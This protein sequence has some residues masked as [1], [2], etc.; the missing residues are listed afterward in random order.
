[1]SHNKIT[2]QGQNPDSSGNV[3]LASLN[4]GDLNNVT[5]SSPTT[6]QVIKYDG[7]GYVNADSPGATVEYIRIGQGESNLYSNSGAANLNSGSALR[8]Y[9]TSPLNTITGA[10]LT[11]YSTSDWYSSFSLPAGKYFLLSQFNVE[12]SASGY[13]AAQLINSSS[14]TRSMKAVVGDNAGA[15]IDGASTSITGLFE[16]SGSETIELQIT[17]ASN[18]DGTVTTPATSTNFIAEN[19]FIYIQKVD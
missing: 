13:I 18:V 6:N 15:L 1:M 16:L 7:A 2:V 17:N 12:F 19:T 8:I 5:I 11:E 9:D 4:I 10:T 14:Q 3:S